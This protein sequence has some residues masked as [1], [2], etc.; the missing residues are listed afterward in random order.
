MMFLQLFFLICLLF[1]CFFFVQ[2]NI[3]IMMHLRYM[4]YYI[5]GSIPTTTLLLVKV[6]GV[7]QC[8]GWMWTCVSKFDSTIRIRLCH[9]DSFRSTM[10]YYMLC[11]YNIYYNILTY[12]I[13]YH[14]RLVYIY[15]ISYYRIS[16][17]SI[18]YIKVRFMQGPRTCPRSDCVRQPRTTQWLHSLQR[19]I[20]LRCWLT[21]KLVFA[22]D[23]L[24]V[25]VWPITWAGVCW[26][27]CSCH[28]SAMNRWK[29]GKLGKHSFQRSRMRY[30][31]CNLDKAPGGKGWGGG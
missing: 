31:S 21:E 19:R 30:I 26:K 8:G 4:R 1:V 10:L 25:V 11:Y 29:G 14:I 22:L 5:D 28:F 3:G 9:I 20:L 13:E 2:I 23:F 7:D 18:C 12:I 15:M 24:W 16:L 6:Q 17:Y 27:S